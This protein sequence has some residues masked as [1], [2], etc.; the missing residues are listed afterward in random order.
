MATGE[1]SEVV[2]EVISQEPDDTD[3]FCCPRRI[4]I[5]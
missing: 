3:R 1:E 4:V 5:M 2:L